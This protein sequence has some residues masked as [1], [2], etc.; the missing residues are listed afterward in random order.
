[1]WQKESVTMKRHIINK[2]DLKGFTSKIRLAGQHGK[3]I[4]KTLE[5]SVTFD[6][7][8]IIFTVCDDG[9]VVGTEQDLDKAIEIYN[10]I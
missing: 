6:T 8:S 9:N 1:M 2:D 4:N 3:G 10:E 7:K 5:A